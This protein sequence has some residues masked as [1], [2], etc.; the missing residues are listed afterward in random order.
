[1]GASILERV[2]DV[3]G[4]VP[5]RWMKKRGDT[6]LEAALGHVEHPGRVPEAIRQRANLTARVGRQPLW[7]G[8]GQGHATRTPDQ[9]KTDPTMGMLYADLITKLEP[10]VVVEFG[11]AFGMSGMYWLINLTGHLYTFEVNPIWADIARSNLSAISDRFTLTVGTFEDNLRVLP[12]LIDVA[13]IDA[14]HT[15]ECV[16]PQFDL[17][18]S[19]CRPGSVVVFDDINFSDDMRDCWNALAFDPRVQA[20][21]ML[22]RRVGI[23]EL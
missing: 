3:M 7:D 20:S 21:A 6:R 11:T 12:D 23:V 18:A 14:I 10:K 22:G 8:Y 1:M 4:F 5:V 9:V 17:V 15:S 2:V 16:N 19:R 13:F